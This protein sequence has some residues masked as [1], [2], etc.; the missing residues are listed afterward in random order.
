[1]NK[2]QEA[3]DDLSYPDI[4]SPCYGDKCGETDCGDCKIRRDI[5]TL[6]ELV[7]KAT[8]KKPHEK[9]YQIKCGVDDIMNCIDYHDT[10]NFIDYHC[11]SCGKKVVSDIVNYKEYRHCYHCGQTIDWSGEDVD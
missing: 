4:Y 6:K 8:P 1:M 5:L 3:L 7:D 11:P 10:M 2:Y 9:Y